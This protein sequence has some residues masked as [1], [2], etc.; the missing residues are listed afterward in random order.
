VHAQE[1]SPSYTIELEQIEASPEGKIQEVSGEMQQQLMEHGYV[2]SPQPSE[3]SFIF[4][5][6]DTNIDFTDI[7]TSRSKTNSTLLRINSADPDSYEIS[8]S[9][10]QPFQSSLDEIIPQTDCDET[11]PC[12]PYIP[13]KWT[14]KDSYGWGFMLSGPD[15]KT[16]SKDETYFQIFDEEKHMTLAENDEVNGESAT[17]LTFKVQVSPEQKEGN[18]NGVIKIIALPKL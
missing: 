17:K 2:L 5:I 15:V 11:T 10:V 9:L 13:N 14:G 18:Y 4:T 6:T 12:A 16:P 1:I 3:T 7:I 8:S